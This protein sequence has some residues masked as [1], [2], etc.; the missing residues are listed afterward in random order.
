MCLKKNLLIS[1]T[2]SA[3]IG[4]GTLWANPNSTRYAFDNNPRSVKVMSQFDTDRDQQI[5]EREFIAQAKD[6]RAKLKMAKRFSSFDA[7][8][9]G[10]VTLDELNKGFAALRQ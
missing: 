8:R 10:Y 1:L 4:I 7:D 5:T 6:E 2:C 3:L 9:S